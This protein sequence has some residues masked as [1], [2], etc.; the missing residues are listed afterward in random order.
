MYSIN[1]QCKCSTKGHTFIM[2]L[3]NICVCVCVCGCGYISLEPDTCSHANHQHRGS[4]RFLI[5]EAIHKV[6]FEI[7][8]LSGIRGSH[9][10]MD[11]CINTHTLT[12]TLTHTHAHTCT[13]IHTYIHMYAYTHMYAH[14]STSPPKAT[15]QCHHVQQLHCITSVPYALPVPS[16]KQPFVYTISNSIYLG[17]NISPQYCHRYI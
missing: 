7:L 10:M 17:L 3:H 16:S 11:A 13:H 8:H 4:T 1:V 15:L 12:H 14:R 6:H 2:F 9:K 5:K